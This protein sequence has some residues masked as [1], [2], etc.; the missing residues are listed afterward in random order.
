MNHAAQVGQNAEL[1]DMY[2]TMG[3]EALRQSSAFE[4]SPVPMMQF[5]VQNRARVRQ[6]NQGD[7]VRRFEEHLPTIGHVQF[8]SVPDRSEPDH[9]ELDF[10]WLLPRLYEAGYDGFVG[11]EYLPAADTASG[12][13]WMAALREHDTE[14]R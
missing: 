10:G 2:Q 8:A 5:L 12:L 1:K 14:R 7:I 4:G 13:N 6:I 9:G 11:A 3:F